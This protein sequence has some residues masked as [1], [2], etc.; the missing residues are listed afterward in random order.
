MTEERNTIIDSTEEKE[1]DFRSLFFQYLYYWPWF[2]VSVL[3]CCIVA[4]VYLRYQAPVYNVASAVLIKEDDKKGGVNNN[5]LA[6]LDG[7]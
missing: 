6:A 2:V 1:I 5:P 4:Y 7:M 3:F